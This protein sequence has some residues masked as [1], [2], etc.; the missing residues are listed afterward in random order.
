MSTPVETAER[1][2]NFPMRVV[3]LALKLLASATILWALVSR[4]GF[5]EVVSKL[6]V[7]DPAMGVLALVLLAVQLI[8]GMS[9]WRM[10]CAALG[11]YIPGRRETLRWIGMGVA[12]SQVLPSSVGGD[13]YRMV[14]LGRLAGLAAA[15]RTVV[16]ERV[17]GLLAL[18]ALALVLSAV[19][20]RLTDSSV[21][22]A[23]YATVSGAM[24]V[25]GVL[26][27]ALS[28]ALARWTESRLI[29]QVATD[30]GAMYEKSTLVAVFGMSVVIH[31]LSVAAAIC[32]NV[33]L[34]IDELQWW[35]TAL[36]VPGA[37]LA[38][39]IPISLGGWG[40]REA[41][42]VFGLAA[43]GISDAAALALSISYGVALAGTGVIGLLLWVAGGRHQLSERLPP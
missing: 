25:G 36:V 34:G 43:F 1:R 5:D 23:T 19:A 9:R 2:G 3:G 39:A 21:A 35:Q 24:L 10:I 33:A 30:F 12:L 16:A 29:Q 4:I 20:S 8:V 41:S 22:F 38:S 14:A 40:V 18:A 17:V 13:A 37:L 7:D 28:R 15:M 42:V 26:A 32:L 31:G 6:K 11:T 27:G